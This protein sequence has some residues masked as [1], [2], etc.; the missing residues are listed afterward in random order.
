L[1]GIANHA[2]H[3]DQQERN[4]SITIAGLILSIISLLFL[5]W[6]VHSWM[7]KIE[8]AED[9]RRLQARRK[10]KEES[11]RKYLPRKVA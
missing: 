2:I 7:R 9:L 5:M 11:R 8:K 1:E 10:E 4:M 6:K 3:T